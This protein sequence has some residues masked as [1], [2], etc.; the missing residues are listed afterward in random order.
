MKKLSFEETK[1]V[2]LNILLDIANYCEQ[3]GLRYFLAYGTLIGAFRHQGFIPWDDDI[4]IQMP[5][6]D[7]NLLI[8]HYNANKQN[9]HLHLI[10]P[11]DPKSKHSFVKIIDTRTVKMEPNLSYSEGYLGIDIDVFPLDG[12]PDS[13]KDF[14]KWYHSLHNIYY[15]FALSMVDPKGNWKRRLSIPLIKFFSGGKIK[16]LNRAAKLHDRY[17]YNSSE[18][19]GVVESSYNFKGNR[20]LKS[21]YENYIMLD[22]AGYKLRAPAGYDSILKALY[23]DYM[24]LPPSDQQITHHTNITYWKDEQTI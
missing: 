23:G 6:D 11:F 3:N 21:C 18:Y 20:V 12:E 8:K 9:D 4:D 24:K 22:F 1:N 5:R 13:E 16:L 2:E 10:S 19:V 14:E 7:Y 17:P 15:L